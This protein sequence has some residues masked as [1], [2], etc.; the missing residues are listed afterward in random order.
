MFAVQHKRKKKDLLYFV[1]WSNIALWFLIYLSWLVVVVFLSLCFGF[2]LYCLLFVHVFFFSWFVLL[3]CFVFFAFWWFI[4]LFSC[5]FFIFLWI[6]LISCFVFFPFLSCFHL[7]FHLMYRK[8]PPFY[9]SYKYV[10]VPW[11]GLCVQVARKL[12]IVE[13]ELERTEERA[14]LNE[15]YETFLQPLHVCTNLY[16]FIFMHVPDSLH[17]LTHPYRRR[18]H[19]IHETLISL[20]L[21]RPMNAKC[22]NN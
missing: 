21:L 10:I 6:F 13:A 19:R 7:C 14:E 5:I 15:R 2:L 12:V 16:T 17:T 3:S 18:T 4:A 22:I 9:I 1:I 20:L 11:S 8:C